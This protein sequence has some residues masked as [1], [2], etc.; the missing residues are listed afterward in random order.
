M[1]TIVFGISMIVLDST[2]VNVAFP[3][4][5]R[6]F[7][8]GLDESAVAGYKRRSDPAYQYLAVRQPFEFDRD[9]PDYSFAGAA[10][11]C[12]QSGDAADIYDCA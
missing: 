8:V 11:S 6:E 1:I 5:R 2:V 3:T 9:K 12:D 7:D 4:L 10:R